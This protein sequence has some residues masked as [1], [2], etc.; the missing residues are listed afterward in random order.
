MTRNR[1]FLYMSSMFL[2]VVLVGFARSFYLRTSFAF[3][4]LPAHLYLHGTAL[5]AWFTLAFIQPWLIK[6][7]RTDIHRKLGVIGIALAMSVVTSGLWTVF[8]RDA[9]EIDEFPTRAAGNLASLM[10]FSMCFT[11][12]VWFRR[13]SAMHK[14]LMLLASIPLLAPALDRLARIPIFNEFFGQLLSWFPAP[15]EIAFATLAFLV[16]LFSVVVNDLISE[17]RV[18]SG[19]YW[20]LFAILIIAPATTY[21]IIDSGAW[22]TF[23]HWAA[24]A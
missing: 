8:L 14:R 9:P 11:L 19:T 23:V 3:P 2:A 12:G 21:A 16:L 4:E 17:R 15:P 5:T 20:G 10:M 6:S 7:R 13:K 22:V 24:K 1:Y 18:L